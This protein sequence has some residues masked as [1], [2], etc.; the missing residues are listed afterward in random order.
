LDDVPPPSS[1]IGKNVFFFPREE[2]DGE[3]PHLLKDFWHASAIL[4]SPVDPVH[5]WRERWKWMG[6]GTKW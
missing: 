4:V 3:P 1:R 5:I 6:L 2:R